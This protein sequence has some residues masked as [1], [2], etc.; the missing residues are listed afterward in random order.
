MNKSIKRIVDRIDA[1]HAIPLIEYEATIHLRF[2]G[3]TTHVFASLEPAAAWARKQDGTRWLVNRLTYDNDNAV[4]ITVVA[5]YGWC[6]LEEDGGY[7]DH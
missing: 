7:F 5:R 6:G 3:T 4:P 1:K 2:G